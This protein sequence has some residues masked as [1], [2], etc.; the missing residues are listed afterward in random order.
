MPRDF[1]L[2]CIN[3]KWKKSSLR[4]IYG[5]GAANFFCVIT[6][7]SGASMPKIFKALLNSFGDRHGFGNDGE[8]A[9]ISALPEESSKIDLKLEKIQNDL[10]E[11]RIA[12]VK[13][14]PKKLRRRSR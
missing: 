8:R 6:L 13:K 12:E 2:R 3:A 1:P 7:I 11:K 4:E 9:N 14:R 10:E 5:N